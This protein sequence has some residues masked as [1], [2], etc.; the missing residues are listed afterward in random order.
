MW[1]C[2]ERGFLFVCF[3]S[4]AFQVT[5]KMKGAS[6]PAYASA[7]TALAYLYL[8]MKLCTEAVP[9]YEHALSIRRTVL[10]ENH[11]KTVSARK[12][13]ALAQAGLDTASAYGRCGGCRIV[14]LVTDMHI[15]C[16]KC[17]AACCG[18][19]CRGQHQCKK[20]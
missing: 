14:K 17:M 4:T 11:H 19:S 12:G 1:R 13:L 8:Q 6:H 10:G 3:L 5:L 7:L 16:P 18:M 2:A 20:Q 9:L 15:H